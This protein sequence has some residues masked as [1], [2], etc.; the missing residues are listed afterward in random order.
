MFDWRKRVKDNEPNCKSVQAELYQYIKDRSQEVYSWK[1]VVLRQ[2]KGKR[3]LDIGGIAHN[4][5]EVKSSY[6]KH[7]K[8]KKVAKYILGVD[9]LEEMVNWINKKGYNFCCADATSNIYLGEKFD[10]VFM[11]D[12]IEHV[13]NIGGLL[14]F[15][16]SHLGQEGIILISTPNPH[17]MNAFLNYLPYRGAFAKANMEHTCWITPTYMN[18]LCY[19]ADLSFEKTYF[20]TSKYNF[21]IEVIS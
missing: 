14:K 17:Y 7:K 4:K 16:K 3:V 8:L 20:W 21:I 10:I 18:E 13:D 1:T 19:R 12:V 2:C 9:I 15:A 6:W 5:R 11:G